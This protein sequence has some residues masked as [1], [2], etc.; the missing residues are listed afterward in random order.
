MTR[1]FGLQCLDDAIRTRWKVMSAQ[2]REGVKSYVVQKVIKLS[3]AAQGEQEGGGQGG[4]RLAFLNKLNYTLVSIV[5]HEWPHNWPNFISDLV[6]SSKASE[7]MCENNMRILCCL[8]EEVF[9]FGQGKLTSVKVKGM[10]EMLN[11][12]FSKVFQLC[13]FVLTENA[14]R[15]SGEGG[16]AGG[17]NKHATSS[18]VCVTLSTLQRFLTWI[19]VGYIFQTSLIHSLLDKFFPVPAYRSLSLLCLT[20]IAG[21]EE[22]QPQYEICVQSMYVKFIARLREVVEEGTDLRRGWEN[23]KDGDVEF[24]QRMALFF[25]AFFKVRIWGGGHN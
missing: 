15:R 5:K 24:V 25:T 2:H 18:L 3:S 17:C 12:E 9:D 6:G 13:D 14:E 1:Y 11:S 10:K 21:L 8:S 4:E 7:G 19:P 20:E 16:G 23:L 22:L